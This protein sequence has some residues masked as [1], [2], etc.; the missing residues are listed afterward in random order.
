MPA[1]AT[2]PPSRSEF[3]RSHTRPIRSTSCSA[4]RPQI[5]ATA[6]A[7]LGPRPSH[8]CPLGSAGR[9]RRRR[10]VR[11]C[12]RRHGLSVVHVA[13]AQRRRAGPG[14]ARSRGWGV[15]APGGRRRPSPGPAWRVAAV[16]G[17]THSRPSR[18]HERGG[19]RRCTGEVATVRNSYALSAH[20]V[21]RGPSCE[22]ETLRRRRLSSATSG[23]PS[24]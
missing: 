8:R 2:T 10:A 19:H 11:G 4:S 17:S 13:R 15:A 3:C 12:R 1:G 18:R 9:L 6:R 23:R 7:C 5:P 16:K 22:V 24:H 14:G 21:F 20:L